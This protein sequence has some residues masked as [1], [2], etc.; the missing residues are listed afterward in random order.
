M[1][2]G[3]PSSGLGEQE[4]AARL[5]AEGFNEL[6]S[7]RPRHLVSIFVDVLR[8]PMLLLLVA[9]GGIYLLLG[10]FREAVL[11]LGSIVLVVGIT[12]YQ[13]QRSERALHAL[14]D[15]SSPRALV[16]R[17]GQRSR[18]PGREVVRGDL[19]VLSEGDRVP[20]DGTLIAC[21]DL[22][23]DESLLTGESIPVDKV[24]SNDG[25]N[26]V[27]PNRDRAPS[28]FSGTLVVRGQGLAEV[29]ATGVLTEMGRIGRLLGE[30]DIEKTPLQHAT[31][32]LTRSMAAGGL[33]TCAV[34]VVVYGATRSDWLTG[35]LVGIT[36]AMSL[37][38]EE[39]PVVLTVFLAL[40]AWR[41]ARQRV[42]T[43]RAAVIEA[44]GSATVLCVDKTGTLTENRMA[45]RKLVV[46]QNIVVDA[47]QISN[48]PL[49][50]AIHDLLRLSILASETEA[51]DPLERALVEIGQRSLPAQDSTLEGWTLV[52]EYALTPELLAMSHVWK[53]PIGPEYLVAAKGAPEAIAELCRLDANQRAAVE[54][55]V[56]SL[57]ETRL[58][59][60]AVAKAFV[61]GPPWPSDQRQFPF[62]F[63]GLVG[64]AD[65][66][67][68]TVPAAIQACKAAGIRVV[69]ITGDYPTTARAI[70]AEAGIG[71]VQE[72]LTGA[73]LNALDDD[74]LKER[75]RHVDVFARVVPEQKLRIVNGFKAAGAVVAMT[76]DGVN[77]APALRAAHIGIA[78]GGRGTDVARE[79]AALV[80]LDDDMASI[81]RAVRMGRRIFD[82]LKKAADYILAIHIPIAG[83]ALVPV[84]VQSPLLLLPAHI[85][86][87]EM[88][89]DP[90]CSIVFEAETEE[91]DIMTRP[92]RDP[93][94]QLFSRASI[95]LSLL[96]GTAVLGALLAV[97]AFALSRGAPDA[98]ARALAF[99]TLIAGNLSLL[100]A[101]RSGRGSLISRRRPSAFMGWLAGGALVFLV[102]VLSVPALREIFRFD[103]P[104]PI[105][106]GV[107]LAAGVVSV[108]SVEVVKALRS[109]RR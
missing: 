90:A 16:I 30:T 88:I 50:T 72:V 6:P 104:R 37:L 42:L 76:G 27:S 102:A 94:E 108:L 62:E 47:G 52:H 49:S 67:R 75:L 87:L 25:E 15:L 13:H 84:L 106:V 51:L 85:V 81:V 38:P 23:I 36:L 53:P 68:P 100:L 59:V 98:E 103:A 56:T 54:Q 32:R 21:N 58:R 10:D 89:I 1:Q 39:L 64:L 48:E 80:L 83:A 95:V 46:E 4:A 9:S 77:D 101:N 29:Q 99:C 43:R 20:A 44:L 109:S 61:L 79:A 97:F 26:A 7:A 63:V 66:L 18:I 70:A 69:M 105:D 55:G 60:I 107:A 14:R 65:P 17:D 71:P 82:N 45:V 35:L 34:V 12:F 86:F 78:M 8:E 96:Q 41:L 73:E 40:G 11:L 28:V 3:R 19:V 5:R 31:A 2:P 91:D 92:P 24:A 74:V 57:A 33:F 93:N 22:S